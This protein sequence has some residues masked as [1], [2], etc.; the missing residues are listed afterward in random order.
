MEE[1]SH[2]QRIGAYRIIRQLGAGGMGKVYE[3]EHVE[4][5]ARRALK[6]FST[7]SEHVEYL[8]KH[9][10]GEGRMLANRLKHP[11]IVRVDDLVVDEDS[12]TPYLGMELVLSPNGQPRTL[13]DEKRDGVSEDK[14][15]GWFKDICEGLA[16]IHSQGVVHRDM[17][18]DNILIGPDGRAVITD[19][20]IA[21]IIDESFRKMINMTVTMVSKDGAALVMGK[22][23]YMS[24]ELKMSGVA[25]F[26]SDAYAVGVILYRLL[27]GSW[28]EPDANLDCLSNFEYDWKPIISQLCNVDPEKRLG[29]DGI[30]AL[31]SLLKRV[32]VE[33]EEASP[34]QADHAL[35]PGIADSADHAA[36]HVPFWRRK[37]I[38]L[39]GVLLAIG[40][41]LSGAVLYLGNRS[42]ASHKK[43]VD[44]RS[45]DYTDHIIEKKN[46]ITVD[47][48]QQ[49][50]DFLFDQDTGIKSVSIVGSRN[51]AGDLV[52]PAKIDGYTVTRIDDSA[53]QDCDG[54]TNVIIPTGIKA[55]G[56]DAFHG[57]SSLASVTIP[58]GATYIA[59]ASF[60]NCNNLTN[61]TI[62][63]SIT[64]IGANA[65]T[66]CR[67]LTSVAMPNNV[68]YIGA[69][70][71]AGCDRLLN[72]VISSNVKSIGPETFS[73]CNSLTNVA[74]P[75]GVK[76]I[77][78]G[79]FMSCHKMT[80]ITIPVGVT[81]IGKQAFQG[82]SSLKTM[83]IPGDVWY[84]GVGAFGECESLME[85]SVDSSNT[86]YFSRGGC[87]LT[88]DGRTLMAAVTGYKSFT[89]PDGVT[90]I[91]DCAFS[92][93][94]EL[95][96]IKIPAS[97]TNIGDYAFVSGSLYAFYVA[98]N[99]PCFKSSSGLLLTKDGEK[100]ICGVNGDVEIPIGVT[101]IEKGAFKYC[102]GLRKVTIPDSVTSV[103]DRAFVGCRG[104]ERVKIPAGVTSI[105]HSAFMSCDSI[106]NL[107][108]SYGVVR[109]EEYAFL[110]CVKLESVTLPQSIE[111][112]GGC[113]FA[114]CTKLKS[115][116]LPCGI[117]SIGTR[118]FLGCSSLPAITIP[119]GVMGIGER[120]F[121][122]CS[123]LTS[124][125]MPRSIIGIGK[126][127][128][129]KT[130]LATV[131]VS[132]G[133]TDRV[134]KLFFD[135]GHDV[136]RIKFVESETTPGSSAN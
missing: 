81:S 31:P 67:G 102:R 105:G 16:Y 125:T 84:I 36:N 28:Y 76:S 29:E 82:C 1:P 91:G 23:F 86:R 131:Y 90:K 70:A 58:T 129:D 111:H 116:T 79:A 108:I 89:V 40:V 17:S 134:K 42:V 10:I 99:N 118:T 27:M 126:N 78:D 3:A 95:K 12:G 59:K 52:I 120:A 66:G 25:T 130:A 51:I 114:L 80:S 97:V 44:N 9:F 110:G 124:V 18:L 50:Y 53:F 37:W 32:D 21:K 94:K 20:G 46:C 2:G 119:N 121:A 34:L 68:R 61:V 62:P 83:I 14:I 49:E 47:G 128:F 96:N 107:T 19:F 54:L 136:E 112:I 115:V 7:E 6:V 56:V 43:E 33:M 122:E 100:L 11:R 77:G 65:F 132:S 30:A 74:I 64:S 73:G 93:H 4:L 75:A 35:Q 92:G 109:I 63:T 133:D 15:V 103:G 26:A 57:C 106:M 88:K 8:R 72:V 38:A 22:V 39:G 104:L 101:S 85:I 123:K 127:A 48:M 71:F 5:R 135:S 113:A 117:E 87:L 45:A 13:A 98:E 69:K 41:S 55:I 24:P 60:M